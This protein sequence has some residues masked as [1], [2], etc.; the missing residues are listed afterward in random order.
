ME[1]AAKAA[2]VST[3]NVPLESML[4]A[5][6]LLLFVYPVDLITQSVAEDVAAKAS[7]LGNIESY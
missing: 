4:T 7:M 5:L 3:V 1:V 6:E 2:E